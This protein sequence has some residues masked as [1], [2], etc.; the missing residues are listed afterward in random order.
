MPRRPSFKP[1]ETPDG[2]M[3]SIPESMS[4]TGKRKKRHFETPKE[5]E[6]FAASLRTQYHAGLRGGTISPELAAM[7]ARAAEMLEPLGM[8]IFDAAKAAV[9]RFNAG[10]S[11]ETFRER[12]A[13]FCDANEAHWRPRYAK[14]MGKIPR[15]VPASFMDTRIQSITPAMVRGAVIKGGASAESTIK[16]RSARIMSVLAGR[17]NKRRMARIAIMTDDQV[18]AMLG[19]CEDAGERRAVALLLFAGIRPD[20]EEG[21]I[22]RLDWADVG[23]SEIYVSAEVSKTGTDRHVPITPRLRE[24]LAGHDAEGPVAPS[25]WKVRWQRLRKSA[26]IGKEQ[27]ITRHTFASHYLSAFGDHAAKQAM[28]H[29]AKSETIFRHYR[30]AITEAAGNAYF[31]LAS[32]APADASSSP[33]ES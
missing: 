25:G 1:L 29:T 28:G 5:A 16:A 22:S 32:A 9:D 3:V 33:D 4:G 10:Q 2:W 11:P 6:K 8:T 13:R 20:A 12:W 7:A 24:L 26:G 30:R 31:E 15:W 19:G 23:A 21:E 18:A 27:D 17:G 14:D